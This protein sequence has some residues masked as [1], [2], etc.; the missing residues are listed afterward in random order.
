[1]EEQF[2][3]HVARMR[4]KEPPTSDQDLLILYGLYKQVTIGDCNIAQP[5]RVQTEQ[6]A[7]WE[8]W[9]NYYGMTRAMAMAKYIEKV[10]E[11][12]REH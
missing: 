4:S 12:T 10:D 6:Y 9:Y 1:M 11:I 8:A 5:W 3:E 7:R 2:N